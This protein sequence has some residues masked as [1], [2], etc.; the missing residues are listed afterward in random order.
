M[1][2]VVG[3]TSRDALSGGF[4]KRIKLKLSLRRT[5]IMSTFGESL[6]A[7]TMHLENNSIHKGLFHGKS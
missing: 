7:G 1:P 3:E 6:E 2:K 4:F 5:Y